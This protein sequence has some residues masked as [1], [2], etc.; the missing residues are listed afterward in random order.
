MKAPDPFSRSLEER[1]IE[2]AEA[3]VVLPK[4]FV[5]RLKTGSTT[6]NVANVEKAVAGGVTVSITDFANGQPGQSIDILGDDETTIVNDPTLILT[7][8][9]ADKLLELNKLYRFVNF[10]GVWVEQQGGGTGGGGGGTVSKFYDPEGHPSGQAAPTY[11]LDF[12]TLTAFPAGWVAYTSG[13]FAA[14]DINNTRPGG[15]WAQMPAGG[16]I[17]RGKTKA[18]IIGAGVDFCCLWRPWVVGNNVNFSLIGIDF[19]NGANGV[20]AFH[21]RHASY[22]SGTTYAYERFG[23]STTSPASWNADQATTPS[24]GL[25]QLRRVGTTVYY[26]YSPDGSEWQEV[27]VASDPSLGT[28]AIDIAII[29]Y[30][31]TSLVAEAG[32]SV[33]RVWTGAGN[34]VRRRSGVL[35]STGGGGGGGGVGT[36][37]R[38]DVVATTASLA[39]NAQEIGSINLGKTFIPVR[40]TVDQ[41]CRVR[42]YETAA[43]ALA[44]ASR[45]PGTQPAGEHGLIL[46]VRLDAI[47]GLAWDVIDPPTG[48]DMEAVPAGTISYIIKN[49]SGATNAV[50]LTVSRLL[51]EA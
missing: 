46:D 9:G 14:H 25:Q 39:N 38:G 7:N 21:G 6:P 51:L 35:V 19:M 8:T 26:G 42:L 41:P 40:I 30:N 34:G 37:A 20:I 4:R 45:G 11:E 32:L 33:F 48:T 18:G 17:W 12:K 43:D 1:V 28:G 36:L 10:D 5:T 44:D 15:L 13:D 22:G 3:H 24:P 50:T 16:S 31:S 49:E 47:T 2:A 27:A 23:S 29:V